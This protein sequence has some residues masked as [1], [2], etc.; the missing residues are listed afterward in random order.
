MAIYDLIPYKIRVIANPDHF[1][2]PEPG[3]PLD[4]EGTCLYMD[5]YG[6]NH[7][8]KRFK[9]G[10]V[11]DM[12]FNTEDDDLCIKIRWDND[13][14]YTMRAGSM[15]HRSSSVSKCMSIWRTYPEY[16]LPT[17]RRTFHQLKPRYYSKPNSKLIHI[18]G[19]SYTIDELS[20]SITSDTVIYEAMEGII[21]HT[22]SVDDGSTPQAVYGGSI[23]PNIRES[24]G[25]TDNKEYAEI[26]FNQAE[27]RVLRQQPNFR[28]TKSG[29]SK[30]F[31]HLLR[32]DE[33]RKTRVRLQAEPIR[34]NTTYNAED[35]PSRRREKSLDERYPAKPE[36]GSYTEWKAQQHLGLKSYKRVRDEYR[37]TMVDTTMP[38]K[39]PKL[40]KMTWD[41]QS[42]SSTWDDRF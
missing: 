31:S 42:K 1:L 4:V 7:N 2:M 39:A 21:N 26:N 20:H 35:S 41:D 8:D 34:Y 27:E 10:E 9:Q 18:G 37:S 5:T 23:D 40:K 32:E 12:I 17:D 38:T 29:R 14:R 28:S 11:L 30:P 19:T 16:D 25:L 33:E 15:I 3:V 13:V 24:G 6:V 36:A 22:I